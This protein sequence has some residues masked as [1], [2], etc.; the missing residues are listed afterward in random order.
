MNAC[1]CQHLLSV[2]DM[3]YIYPCIYA[4]THIRNIHACIKTAKAHASTHTI[5]IQSNT[6]IFSQIVACIA[7]VHAC[8]HVVGHKTTNMLYA[9]SFPKVI[10]KYVLP[11][12]PFDHAIGQMWCLPFDQWHGQMWCHLTN[13]MVKCGAI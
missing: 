11:M 4:H 1:K 2:D 5:S 7:F 8:R 13:G 3:I 10:S 12:V 6:R 9:H